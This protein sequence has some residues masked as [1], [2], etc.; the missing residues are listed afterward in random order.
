M[1]IKSFGE[2]QW[3]EMNDV[4]NETIRNENE[5]MIK[6]LFHEIKWYPSVNAC[7]YS[8]KTYELFG[9]D[10][11]MFLIK[12]SKT[13][14]NQNIEQDYILMLLKSIFFSL[15]D[16]N[17]EYYP[18]TCQKMTH[19]LKE[20]YNQLSNKYRS[21]VINSICSGSDIV[22]SITIIQNLV[23]P[24][25]VPNEFQI[26]LDYDVDFILFLLE[27]GF[28]SY[29][30]NNVEKLRLELENDNKFPNNENYTKKRNIIRENLKI[31]GAVFKNDSL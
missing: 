1:L 4:Y 30:N 18:E 17:K 7:F 15:C 23:D 13:L 27:Y 25:D 16:E 2:P 29:N 21:E 11:A 3:T 24:N 19:K 8:Q 6:F 14:I 31:R 26:S 10:T 5:E 20:Y 22:N 28:R 12:Y 9:H